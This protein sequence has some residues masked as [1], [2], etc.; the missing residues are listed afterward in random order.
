[1]EKGELWKTVWR[2]QPLWKTVR[3]FLKRL[4]IEPAYDPVFALLS[5][6]TKDTD[7]VKRMDTCTPMFI[8][9]MSTIAKLWKEPR[10]PSTDEELK[11]RLGGSDS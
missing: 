3:R 8:V 9:A 11:G 6:Y 1:M 7:I 4:K 10:S 5:I 2:F